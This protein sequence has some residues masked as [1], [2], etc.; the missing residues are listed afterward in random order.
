MS[1]DAALLARCQT[2]LKHG[3]EALEIGLAD[4]QHRL[5]LDYLALLHKWNRAYNLTA[6]RDPLQMVERHLL[7]S[8]SVGPFIESERIIDVGTGPGLPGIPLAILFPGKRFTLLDSNGK[9]TRFLQQVKVE[10]QLENIL[11][12]HGRVE[13]HQPEQRYDEVISR[14][15]AS[16]L[17]MLT[18]TDSVCADS[19]RFLAMKGQYPDQELNQL[20][21]EYRLQAAHRLQVPGSQAERHLLIINRAADRRGIRTRG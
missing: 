14:A 2:S 9:R 6:V 12:H 18:W 17:D 8:L 16:I 20:P 19:G 13:S 10:L 1:I 5:L 7:D 11:I 15:F 21:A 4:H 3:A